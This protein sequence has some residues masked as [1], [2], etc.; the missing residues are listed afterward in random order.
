[1]YLQEKIKE[2]DDKLEL[3]LDEFKS[4]VDEKEQ[5]LKELPPNRKPRPRVGQNFYPFDLRKYLYEKSGVDLT[6]IYGISESTAL[7]V[8]SEI[9]FS[10]KSWPSS[11]HFSS[12]LG[13]C[14][15]NKKSGGRVLSSATKPVA[16]KIATALRM[17][18]M[19]IGRTQTSL[20]SFYRRIKSRSSASKAITAVAHK[21]AKII[22]SMISTGQ[23]FAPLDADYYE[24][25][26]QSRL[27]NNLKKKAQE[28][29]YELVQTST[30]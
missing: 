27:L 6:T 15:N 11:G 30:I 13:L 8:L 1:L 7:T 22:Y 10:V 16:N 18:A 26:Y 4:K 25:T 9:G 3:I 19:T 17:S 5:P 14:P 24:K 23:G 29:G 2:C 21:L 12:W 20:G 28:L